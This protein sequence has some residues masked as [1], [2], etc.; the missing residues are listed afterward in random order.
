MLSRRQV[1]EAS[2]SASGALVLATWLPGC[3]GRPAH[4][5]E[6]TG[7]LAPNAWIRVAPDDVVTLVLD[8]VEMGQGTMT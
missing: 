6:A 5:V 3:G 4:Y 2:V 1:L 8:R 7:E